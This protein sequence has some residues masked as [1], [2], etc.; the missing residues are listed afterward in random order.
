MA[1]TQK[2]LSA[3]YALLADNATG[4]ISAQD[5]RDAF[6]SWRMSH[7]QIYIPPVNATETAIVSADVY[8][9][10][11]A[12][13]WSLTTGAASHNFDESDGNG[14]L[15]YTGAEPVTVH[16]A[17]SYSIELSS[18]TNQYIA[19]SMGVNGTP[20]TSSEQR[21]K[22][23]ISGDLGAGAAHLITTLNNGDYLSM[24]AKNETSTANVVI[25]NANLQA[26]G[27]TQ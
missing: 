23:G 25:T 12:P 9:E 18:G 15:T 14:R 2:T 16:C 17:L 22:V 26:I 27:M 20:D 5:L 21:R 8:V 3:I 19:V 1:Q 10:V 4:A 24:F 6:E 11:T 13:A 7:G